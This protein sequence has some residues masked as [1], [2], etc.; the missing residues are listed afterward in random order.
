MM[1]PP[2]A[3]DSTTVGFRFRT[4]QRCRSRASRRPPGAAG[5]APTGDSRDCAAPRRA[6]SALQIRAGPPIQ[7]QRFVLFHINR[8]VY[9]AAAV[10]PVTAIVITKNEADA[11]AD[12]LASLSWADE[13]IVVDAEST[14]DTVAIARQFTER[15]YV[16]PWNGYV[17]Q[18]NHAALLATH[19]WIFSLDADE[20]VTEE[21]RER[22]ARCSH[23]SRRCAA[24]GCRA[25]RS[26]WGAGCGRPTCIRTTSCGCTTG[27]SAH[28]TGCTCTSRSRSRRASAGYLKGEL[29][30]Y[31][32]KDLSEHLIRM[33]RYTTL[34][35]QQMFEKGKRATRL[36]LLFHPPVAFARN[37]ILK[38][39]FRDGKAGAH[40]L[41]REL[42]YVML[43]FAKLWELQRD[44]AD[45]DSDSDCVLHSR[46]HG[47]DV[48]GRTA[49]GAADR[50]RSA[51]TGPPTVLVAHPEGELAGRASEG[52]DLIRLAP[53]AEVDLHA[54]WKLSRI[55][56]ELRPDIVH[57]HDPHAVALASLALSFLT[58]GKVPR[59]CRVPPR[60]IPSRRAMRSRAGNTIRWTASSPPRTPSRR[61]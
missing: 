22:S 1:R 19:D 3:G 32:Y 41:A 57:A 36:E 52:H 55:V 50:A 58:T 7:L 26:I 25:C 30:H 39:G 53:R 8:V 20:R 18:K 46:R 28:G 11:I 23:R 34:A 10:P 5:P 16:R 59:P 61:C 47:E 43:K 40:H 42:Y 9:D 13:I 24:S 51:R 12:A 15:V 2:S 49:A 54:A 21:L 60:R 37:Y 4:C 17:D 27:V 48:A 29:Q 6:G 33:D 45:S 35:A 56:K 14:D 44:Y 31:P 38:G